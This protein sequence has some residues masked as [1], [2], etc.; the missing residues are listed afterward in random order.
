MFPKNVPFT[1]NGYTQLD[2]VGSVCVWVIDPSVQL[3]KVDEL[4]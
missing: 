2:A 4:A 1:T 3:T